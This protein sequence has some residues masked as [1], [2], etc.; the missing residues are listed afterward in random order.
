M[1]DGAG[2]TDRAEMTRLVEVALDADDGVQLQ[3]RQ[4]RLRALQADLPGLDRRNNVLRNL[5]RVDFEPDREGGLRTDA[6]TDAAELASGDRTVELERAAPEGLIAEGVVAKDPS[7]LDHE[8]ARPS[9]GGGDR[10]GPVQGLDRPVR[11][12]ENNVEQENRRKDDD[13][14]SAHTSHA[15]SSV[16]LRTL[17]ARVAP[18]P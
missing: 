14:A 16:E 7:P 13:D 9:R 1:A 15:A 5:R 4:R 6:R 18:A 3:E 12:D 8:R 11:K 2:E 10:T 17:G